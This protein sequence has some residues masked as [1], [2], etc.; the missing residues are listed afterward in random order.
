[1]SGH[2]KW[3]TIKHKKGAADKKRAKVFTKL[4]K[5]IT[6]AARMGG[7]DPGA[8][9]RLRR[10]ID[11]AKTQNMPK[12]NVD[13]AIKK[14]TG[15]MDGVNYEEILYE[16]YGPGGVAVMVEC[17]T[18]NKNRTIADVRYIFNKAGGNVGTD[19][20]VAW[21]FDK[22]GVITISKEHA[23]EETLM[24]VAL[25]AGA[26]DIKDEGETFDVLTAP[27]DFDTVKD[28]IDGAQIPCEVAEISMVPQNTTA[29]S[30][31][32][33]EQMVRFMEALDDNDDVQNFY[34]NADIP[35]EAFDAM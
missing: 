27:E 16:G 9:P 18:D 8:N 26:E 1:M 33:A 12:D 15:D 7:G 24:E 29:V 10:A 30:G 31:K 13:R 6:V 22:K 2:S 19:G 35:D 20:C 23:N 28:A 17:L 25:E 14:G 32:E 4:I 21:M 11:S 3:S 5:E 34:T